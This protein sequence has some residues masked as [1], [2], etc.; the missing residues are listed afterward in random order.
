MSEPSD[1]PPSAPRQALAAQWQSTY[2]LLQQRVDALTAELQQMREERREQQ[3]QNDT[4]A[5]RLQA[6]LE[7]LPAAV[8]VIDGQGQIQD[9]NPAAAALFGQ[10]LHRRLWREV[11]AQAFLPQVPG[12]QEL[13]LR[14]GRLVTLST[15]PLGTSPGQVLLFHDVTETRQLQQQLHHHQ[16]LVDMGRMVAGL[17]HQIRTPLATALLYASQ[18]TQP[19]LTEERRLRFADKSVAGLKQLERLIANMLSYARGNVD[20]AEWLTTDTLLAEMRA[21]LEGQGAAGIQCQWRNDAPAVA[22]RGNRTMLLSAWQNLASNAMQALAGRGRLTLFCRPA[23]GNG[24]ELGV[25]DD[26]PGVPPEMQARLFE[27][28]ASGRERGTGLGLAI[29]RTVA[30]AHHGDV[31]FRSAPGDTT[32]AMRL[33]AVE[34]TAMQPDD[35]TP[36]RAAG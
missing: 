26:G 13:T 22:L 33:P 8:L 11:I 28:F 10:P 32:F 17:A 24:V 9:H 30:K 36:R 2:G 27:P 16:R 6:L 7:A 18:L 20:G 29:V 12:A 35:Q 19:T 1:H 31:W 3:A 15:S 25:E 14:N 34:Q 4:L 23:G 21:L 5:R